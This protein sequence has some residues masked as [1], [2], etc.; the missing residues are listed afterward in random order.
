MTAG[1][2]P[3]LWGSRWPVISVRTT[4][5]SWKGFELGLEGQP[6]KTKWVGAEAEET[7]ELNDLQIRWSLPRSWWPG[8]LTVGGGQHH[9]WTERPAGTAE[10]AGLPEGGQPEREVPLLKTEEGDSPALSTRAA[11]P[12]PEEGLVRRPRGS[13]RPHPDTSPRKADRHERGHREAH[14][15]GHL[16]E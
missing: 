10:P 9:G 2:W 15:A 12:G 1:L 13:L 16:P 7:C 4:S 6:R 8:C 11:R 5:R 3:I 14:A